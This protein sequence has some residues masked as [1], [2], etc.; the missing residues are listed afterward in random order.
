MEN[1]SQGLDKV[2]ALKILGKHFQEPKRTFSMLE[3]ELPISFSTFT[4]R[5]QPLLLTEKG[6]E[7]LVDISESGK[8]NLTLILERGADGLFKKTFYILAG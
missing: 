5:L 8:A 3:K 2:L 1:L 7:V 4:D 6:R